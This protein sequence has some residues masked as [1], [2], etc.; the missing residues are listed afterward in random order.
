[1]GTGVHTA[2][3]AG[4]SRVT[5]YA[6]VEPEDAARRIDRGEVFLLDVRNAA[7][8]SEGH[9]PQA[10]HIMLGHLVNR[11]QEVP[12]DKPVL[13]QCRTGGRSA[14][15]ASILQAH[16]FEQV[17]NMLGGYE[18]WTKLGLAATTR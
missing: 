16:G 13:V 18:E 12:R 1:M 17:Q 10:T 8:W 11:V 3:A 9:I 6:E 2:A 14:I 4:G 15:A 5:S 7:E